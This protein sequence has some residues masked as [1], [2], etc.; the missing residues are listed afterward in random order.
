[1]GFLRRGNFNGWRS[2][3]VVV[4]VS[5]SGIFCLGVVGFAG[6]GK[7]AGTGLVVGGLKKLQSSCSGHSEARWQ[8]WS[9]L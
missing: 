6:L 1:M 2:V 7:R 5:S 9:Q 4:V 3:V 8:V